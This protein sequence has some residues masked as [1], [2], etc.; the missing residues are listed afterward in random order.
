MEHG[1]AALVLPDSAISQVGSRYQEH[2][3]DVQVLVVGWIYAVPVPRYAKSILI[4]PS[5]KEIWSNH[6]RREERLP[7]VSSA[8]KY[9]VE[10]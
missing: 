2:E 4:G 7:L 1:I 5:V 8:N 6:F 9:V 10:S 3:F